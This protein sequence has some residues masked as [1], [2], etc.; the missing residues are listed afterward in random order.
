MYRRRNILISLTAA[1]LSGLL[2]YAVYVLQLRQI[3]LQE[4][5]EVVVPLRFIPAGE[6]LTAELLGA[7]AIPKGNYLPGMLTKA[8]E[9]VGKETAVPL[10]SQE[11]ILEWKIDEYRLLPGKTESTF[12]I[13]RDY[14]MSV[15]NGIRAGDRVL[16]YASGAGM[17]SGKLF[18]ELITVA[19]VKTSGNQE[20]D[21]PKNPNLL[22]MA[23][24]DKASMYA[25][26]RDA[27]GMIDYVN[28]NLTERQWLMIDR[29]CKNG[30]AKLVIAFSPRSFDIP[31]AAAE[32]VNAR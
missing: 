5:K 14:V 23:N 11:P 30:T 7:K 16:L 27:N 8:S 26:R 32:E 15:S 31:A 28:L 19:S 9:A 10:G 21:D 25:S 3:D 1:I 6:R 20:I 18:D 12:Q 2:V 4:T 13:P 29:L 17:E 22:S 24:G